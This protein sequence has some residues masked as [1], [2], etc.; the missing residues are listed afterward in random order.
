MVKGE[1]D[2]RLK[3]EEERLQKA[4]RQN[5]DKKNFYDPEEK[6]IV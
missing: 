6:A 1:I 2:K 5:V 4:Y 3:K